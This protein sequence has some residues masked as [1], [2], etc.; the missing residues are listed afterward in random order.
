M[1]G[2]AAPL[3]EPAVITRLLEA[4]RG[5]DGDALERLTPLVYAELR[6][7]CPLSQGGAARAYRQPTELVHEAFVRL[8][9][10]ET[11]DFRDRAHFLA[12]SVW[13]MRQILVDH[14]RSRLAPT[15]MQLARVAPQEAGA[16]Y[17]EA[18]EEF[19][20]WQREGK[21]AGY[22]GRRI[23]EIEARLRTAAGL[24][25]ASSRPSKAPPRRSA[26]A[27]R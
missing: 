20:S 23:E 26:S 9:R 11:P 5:G 6:R 18:V 3:C 13:Q 21:A 12:I 15:L 10:G 1:P 4:W 27:A 7:L 14:A 16:L 2:E 25:R 17:A 24:A 8:I 19:R 22:A